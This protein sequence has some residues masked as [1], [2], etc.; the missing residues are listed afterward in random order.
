MGLQC[1]IL[2]HA[3]EDAGVE[4]EREQ[5]GSEVV[6]TERTI[7]RCRRCGAERVVSENTEVTAVVDADDVDIET[8]GT[9]EGE[10]EAPGEPAPEAAETPDDAGGGGDSGGGL[11]G[12]VERSGTDSA[13]DDEAAFGSA[14]EPD[15]P[16]DATAVG[17][18]A[19]GIDEEPEPSDPAE[20]D[21]EI[22][23]DDDEVAGERAPGEWPDEGRD[24]EEEDGDSGEIPTDPPTSTDPGAAEETE[25]SLSG[26]TVP[27][28]EIVCPECSFS[29]EANSG[30]RAGDPCP[31]CNA[32]L[33][34]ERNQ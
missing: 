3:F 18:A 26:I 17:E 24:E 6:T 4:R 32:W 25:E 22:L 31:E 21:A 2:G 8:E 20:E 15:P 16:G 11:A 10:G 14:S 12:A 27:E 34:A 13:D 23:T 5:T 19:V 9:G 29:I 30:Y 33:E 7:E 28:G 1:S